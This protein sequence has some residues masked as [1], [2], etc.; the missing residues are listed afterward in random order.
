MDESLFYV[1]I[2]FVPFHFSQNADCFPLK[3]RACRLINSADIR[4]IRSIIPY[5]LSKVV[6]VP[7]FP[8]AVVSNRFLGVTVN[9]GHICT[10]KKGIGYG[11]L[12]H[13]L[14][15]VL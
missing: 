4:D 5:Q 2:Q 1:I 3:C 11:K 15:S 7:R 14:P 13:V 6:P 9:D 10:V 12:V 8:R